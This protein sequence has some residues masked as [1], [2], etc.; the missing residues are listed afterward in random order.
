MGGYGVP[1]VAGAVKMA[2]A[3]GAAQVWRMGNFT[4]ST[5]MEAFGRRR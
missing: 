5:F 3:A 2:S 4:M 1:F